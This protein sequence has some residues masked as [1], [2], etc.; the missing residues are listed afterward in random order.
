MNGGLAPLLQASAPRHLYWIV[1]T[2]EAHHLRKLLYV[3]G[4]AGVMTT[5]GCATALVRS[6]STVGFQH[7][8]PATAFDGQFFFKAGVKGDPLFAMVDPKEKNTPVARLAE[9]TLTGRSMSFDRSCGIPP[10]SPD[11]PSGQVAS[12]IGKD[13]VERRA[14]RG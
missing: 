14:A 2:M 9:C 7:V 3:L 4:V 1:R 8:F 12:S 5:S 13:R 6:K 11:L 10:G